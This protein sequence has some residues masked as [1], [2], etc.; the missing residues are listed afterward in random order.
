MPATKLWSISID[1]MPAL[2]W[3]SNMPKRSQLMR[4]S[5]GSKPRWASSGMALR[6][7]APSPPDVPDTGLIAVP[8]GLSGGVDTNSS[9]NVRGS[10]YRSSPP[11]VNVITTWVC[12][13]LGS[14]TDFTLR[15]WPLIP[16]CTTSVSPLS[17]V[18][19]R[20]LPSRPTDLMVRPSSGVR[21]CLAEG[22]RRTERPL[23]TDTV[24]IF[25]PG[26]SRARS[27]RNV[28]TSGNSGIL[29]TLPGI[30]SR[31]LF[32]VFF[33]SPHA[34]A[35]PGA[36]DEHI[37]LVGPFVVRARTDHD[38]AGRAPSVVD[39]LLLQ[40]ALVV[41]VAGLLAGAG[42]GVAQLT[43]DEQFGGVPPRIEVDRTQDRLEGVRQDRGLRP[44]PGRLL[45]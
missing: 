34:D 39:G 9:P 35:E 38:V 2:C 8:S 26:T 16:R 43:Q 28:S 14:L 44:S 30:A 17:R 7:A 29:Q 37:G 20:Y 31:F 22:C 1:L 36:S 10:T 19:S 4:S 45:S 24:L 42:D 25:F 41:E 12:L 11:W 15:S 3:C 40:A 23:A 5:T 33:G 27:W 21:K 6:M 18:M 13:G 32:G